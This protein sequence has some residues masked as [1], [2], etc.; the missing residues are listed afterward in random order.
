MQLSWNKQLVSQKINK[1]SVLACSNNEYSGLAVLV[2]VF[3]CH[4]C[5][6]NIFLCGS[7][8]IIIKVTKINIYYKFYYPPRHQH[9][10]AFLYSGLAVVADSTVMHAQEL[11]RGISTIGAFSCKYL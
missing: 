11:H 1:L 7:K 2:A 3:L 5:S 6:L 10:S 8:T 4:A 9:V